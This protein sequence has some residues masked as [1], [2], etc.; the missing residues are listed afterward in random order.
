MRCRYCSSKETRVT[1]TEHKGNQTVRY[2][3]CL[4]CDK[5]YKTIETYEIPKFGYPFGSPQHPNQRKRGE[6]IHSSVLTESNVRHI[7]DLAKQLVTYDNIAKQFGI[8]KST[9]YRIVKRRSWAH[10]D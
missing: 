5:R 3:R 2:C 9:V 1:C 7:R 8:N 10:V 4:K 6:G